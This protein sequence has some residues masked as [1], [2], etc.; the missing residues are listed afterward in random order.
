MSESIHR[1]R[2]S[3][4]GCVDGLRNIDDRTPEASFAELRAGEK[5]FFNSQIS[6]RAVIGK[7]KK[8]I[9]RLQ[10]DLSILPW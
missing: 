8:W 2:P 9:G 3:G 6:L 7:F 10:G 1:F 4:T 5:A